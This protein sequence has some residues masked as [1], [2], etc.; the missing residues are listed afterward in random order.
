VKESD[1]HKSAVFIEEE[2]EKD[3]ERVEK[4]RIASRI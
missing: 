2:K 3:T 4:A 1:A